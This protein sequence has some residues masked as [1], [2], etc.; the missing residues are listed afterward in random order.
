[1]QAC[2]NGERSAFESRLRESI[3]VLRS[4]TQFEWLSPL[5]KEGYR[6][7]R[8]GAML[9]ALGLERL[10]PDLKRFWPGRGPVW[11]ALGRVVYQDGKT[12]TLLLEAKSHLGEYKSACKAKSRSWARI[13]EA[14]G[15]LG[16]RLGASEAWRRA[17][18]H[19][20]YQMANRLAF[21]EF[22]HAAGTEV[23]LVNI[24]FEGDECWPR[25]KRAASDDWSSFHEGLKGDLGL[26]STG[27][28]ELVKTVVVPPLGGCARGRG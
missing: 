23:L 14:L 7:F 25:A 20:Y 27:W 9:R 26:T 5:S 18:L 21:A 4:A 12:T 8:D 3:P 15:D 13:S 28:P 16:R 11:D 24:C 22:L 1:M 10:G 2:V 17:S 19:D 6:E